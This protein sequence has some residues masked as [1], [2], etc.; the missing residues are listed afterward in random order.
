MQLI[1]DNIVASMV[2]GVVLLM[3]ISANM[4]N[5][6]AAAESSAFFMLQQQ[7]IDFTS[8]IQRDMQNLSSVIDVAETDNAFR[9]MA[10]V[11]EADTTKRLVRY[12]REYTGTKTDAEGN[13]VPVYRINRYVDGVI[14]GGSLGTIAE[15]SI[16]ALNED[17]AEIV[18]PGDAAGVRIVLHAL[19][20]VAVGR[21]D[22][23]AM[24]G[25]RWQATYRPQLLRSQEL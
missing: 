16:V 15:W 14:A 3:M 21:N 17:E 6:V 10:Q 5:Q 12:E 20:P 11:D 25:T 18:A 13:S 23:V 7:V 8:F 1:Y 24:Q 9:F 19:P 2:G 4:R 22:G